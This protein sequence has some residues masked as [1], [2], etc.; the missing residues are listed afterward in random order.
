MDD[1]ITALNTLFEI[2][3]TLVCALAPFIPFV[4]DHMFQL[5]VAYIPQD[6]QDKMPDI[7]SVHFQ[8][9]PEARKELFDEEMQR[10]V[11]R[12]QK[13]IELTRVARERKA[14][15]LKTPLQT[16]VVIAD[17]SF[18]DDISSLLVYIKKELNVREVIPESD[19]AKYNVKLGATVAD[20]SKLGK[21]L[22][23]AAQLVRKVLPDL[24]EEQIKQYLTKGH[25]VVGGSELQEGDL[26]ITRA[27][28]EGSSYQN[29]EVNSDLEALIMLDPTAH[30]HLQGEAITRDVINRIQKLRKK[31]GLVPTDDVR[32]EYSVME[33]PNEVDFATALDDQKAMLSTAL[34]GPLIQSPT[35]LHAPKDSIIAEEETSVSKATCVFRLLKL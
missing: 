11:R 1:T 6:M 13:V 3:Y 12:M 24:T 9:F 28:K 20:W 30:D 4:T 18:L 21:R 25:L 17:Q 29:W 16:L 32:M 14:I 23:G 33:N 26:T 7:R 35:S 10:K 22:K 15:G 19:G 34:R 31:A 5:L 27:L 8:K 2:L